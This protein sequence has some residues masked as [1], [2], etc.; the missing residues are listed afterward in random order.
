MNNIL[1]IG[2]KIYYNSGIMNTTRSKGA[3]FM[4]KQKIYLDT[5]VISHL[6]QRDAP[7]KMADT[8]L[9]WEEIKQGL[10]DV[11]ISQI[12]L[13]EVGA[14]KAEK[15][16]L[17][18]NYLAEIDYTFVELSP[19]INAYADKLIDADI[20]TM[21]SHDDC[22]HIASAVASNCDILLSWNFKHILRVKTINGVR[23]I[24]AILGYKGI[25]II[26]PSMIV[27]RRPE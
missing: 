2:L 6:D 20:L 22:L 9:L 26:P 17:L 11:A 24:S 5:S 14:N 25:D 8:L 1:Q 18:L 3:D 4:R 15:R 16:N 27:E 12:T 10:Y 19:E 7:D 13:D 23:S 21:K